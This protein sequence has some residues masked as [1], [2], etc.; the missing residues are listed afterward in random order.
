VRELEVFLSMFLFTVVWAGIDSLVEVSTIPD[1]C[2]ASSPV[3]LPSG[4]LTRTQ[5]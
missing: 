3:S 1:G 5:T 4:E 2:F